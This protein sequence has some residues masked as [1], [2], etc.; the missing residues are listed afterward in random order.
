MTKVFKVKQKILKVLFFGFLVLI[1][2]FFLMFIPEKKQT[3]ILATTTSTYDSGLLDYLFPDF[4]EKYKM[5]VQVISVGTGQAIKNGERGDVDVIL[6]HAPNAE[7]KFVNEGYGIN[8]RCVMYNDFIVIGPK[9][10]PAGIKGKKVEDAFKIISEKQIEFISRG[11]DSGTYK[12]EMEIWNLTG[13]K[14]KGDWYK[15]VGAGMAD[16]IR[17]T[18]ERLAYTLTDRGTYLSLKDK[19]DLVPLVVGDKIL[20]NPYGAIAVNPKLNPNINYKGAMDFISWLMSEETQRK[21]DSF[22]KD[23]ETLFFSLKGECIGG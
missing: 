11:D 7:K 19:I 16:T 21:I 6:I 2:I 5:E 12:K 4:Q 15:E 13:T 8:R 18:N 20:L 1:L 10:G 23:N 9:N 22:K 3:L 17:I 14:P